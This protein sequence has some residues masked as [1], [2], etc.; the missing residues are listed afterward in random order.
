MGPTNGQVAALSYALGAAVNKDLKWESTLKKDIGF[1]ANFLNSKLTLTADYYKSN[2]S[3]LLYGKPLPLSAGKY[4]NNN[5]W[6]DP[7]D[8]TINGGGIE[9]HG[10]EFSAGWQD[11]KGDF[12]YSINGNLSIDR[13]SVTDLQGR[14]LKES[15][16]AVGM[17][18]Y[19]WYGYKSNGIVKTQAELA[20]HPYL[21]NPSNDFQIGLG[22]IWTVDT[23]GRDAN[24]NL[25][26]KPDGK[27]TADDR[28]FIGKKYP[29][30][31]Y[32]LAANVGWKRWELQIVGYGSQG[33][34]L[35]TMSDIN[36]YFQ[37]TSNEPVRILNRWEATLNP[38]GNMPRVTKNDQ[39]HNATNTASFWLCDGSF[40]KINN[41]N[42]SYSVPDNICQKI[43]MKSLQVYGSI[44]NFHTFTKYPGG[45][46]DVTDQGM[47]S[48]PT[49]KTPQPRTWILG[50]KA[51]F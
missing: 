19:S 48:Q 3:N 30:F 40:F 36:G 46:V 17:P 14:D 43:K 50:I 16:L 37:Y 34:D 29:D 25:T 9:N 39:A 32:G 4:F 1:D 44:N 47:W 5:G 26:G 13:N 33:F 21:N 51:S 42:L 6:I 38:N 35:N 27:I 2:T 8:P 12:T 31:T 18:I 10:F 20:A 24:G 45:E 28:Q 49:T 22:D 41:I 15:G 23:N 7:S 11:K